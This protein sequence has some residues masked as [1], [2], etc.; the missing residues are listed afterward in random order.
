MQR[1]LWGF[2]LIGCCTGHALAQ[3]LTADEIVARV[4]ARDVERQT[5]LAR[6]G[7][8]RTYRVTYK[9]PMGNRSAEVTARMDFSAPDQKH[10]TVI[11]ETG[12]EMFCHKVLRK[13]M[14]AEQE[15]ALQA[16]HMKAMLSSDN[17]N[18]KLVGDD[19]SDGMK[20]WVLEVSPK[21]NSRFTYKG[22]VW[23]SKGDYAVTRIVGSPAKNPSWI[24][25]NAKF[26]YRYARKGAFWLPESNVTVSHVR[27]GG[28]VTLTV[29]YGT[30][31]ITPNTPNAPRVALASTKIAPAALATVVNVSAQ[32]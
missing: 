3:A 22:K 29:D 1:L 8:E 24:S 15:G 12:S 10:F 23:I 21:V 32:R 16:N 20:S 30:Y 11:S 4:N 13:M 28:E 18:L 26:D 6:Y 7:S 2:L 25:S 31:D 5:A 9:G 27:M 17:Y 19:E 14:E